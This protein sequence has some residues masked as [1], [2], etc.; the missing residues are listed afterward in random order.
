MNPESTPDGLSKLLFLVGLALG[1][2]RFPQDKSFALE[3]A[4]DYDCYHF[5]VTFSVTKK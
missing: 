3:E 4:P 5:A 1:V 2:L